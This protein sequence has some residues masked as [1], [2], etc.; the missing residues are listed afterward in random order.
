[1]TSAREVLLVYDKECPVCD[2]YCRAVHIPDLVGEL[3]LVIA[4]EDTAVKGEI[5][6]QGLDL[7]QGMVVKVEGALYYGADAIRA[8]AQM[9]SSGGT[10]I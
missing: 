6:R 4:R 10:P 8:L 3:R 9:S 1:V 2:A 5:T 7:D